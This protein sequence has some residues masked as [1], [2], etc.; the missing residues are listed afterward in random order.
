MCNPNPSTLGFL[1]AGSSR[2]GETLGLLSW[3]LVAGWVLAVPGHSCCRQELPSDW[4]G[5]AREGD[6][7]ELRG[8]SVPHSPGLPVP[9]EGLLGV[10]PRRWTSGI[11]QGLLRRGLPQC[12][13]LGTDLMV[14]PARGTSWLPLVMSFLLL[15]NLHALRPW[16]TL[17]FIQHISCGS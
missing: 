11:R 9:I 5:V 13:G 8:V 2:R 14:S 15:A 17:G 6:G 3:D 10:Q 16:D 12:S 1:S 4:G 7:S